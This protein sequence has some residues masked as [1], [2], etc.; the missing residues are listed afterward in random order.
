MVSAKVHPIKANYA[1]KSDVKV[2]EFEEG[3][4]RG[5]EQCKTGQVKAFTDKKEFLDHLRNL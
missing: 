5:I 2:V 3:V 4:K 1:D